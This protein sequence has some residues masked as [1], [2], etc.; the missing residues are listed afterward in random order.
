MKEG[1]KSLWQVVEQRTN[2]IVGKYSFE[3]DAMVLADFQNKHKVWQVNGGIPKFL[4][5]WVA[6]SYE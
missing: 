6:G 5:N 3:D 1:R 4:W 2:N